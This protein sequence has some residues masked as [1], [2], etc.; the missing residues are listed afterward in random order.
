ML[1][2]SYFPEVAGKKLFTDTYYVLYCRNG[3][4]TRTIPDAVEGISV[5]IYWLSMIPC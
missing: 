4:K 5:L 2:E 1:Q 3:L